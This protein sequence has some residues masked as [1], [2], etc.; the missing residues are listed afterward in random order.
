VA[1]GSAIANADGALSDITT[2][3]NALLAYLRTRGDIAP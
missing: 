2:K 1:Q 3:F